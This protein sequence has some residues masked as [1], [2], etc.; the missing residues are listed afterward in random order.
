[1]KKKHVTTFIQMY[2]FIISTKGFTIN[3]DAGKSRHFYRH[4][5]HYIYRSETFL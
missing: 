3:E 5:K 1:M 4:K 2:E